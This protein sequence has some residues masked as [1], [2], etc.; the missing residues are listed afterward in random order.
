VVPPLAGENPEGLNILSIIR[1]G[2]NCIALRWIAPG[3]S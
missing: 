2:E 3:A 1:P